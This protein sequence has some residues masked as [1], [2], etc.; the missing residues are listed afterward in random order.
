MAVAAWVA[1]ATPRLEPL[2]RPR[3]TL[4]DLARQI[5]ERSFFGPSVVLSA[6]TGALGAAV[7]FLPA[8]AASAGLGTAAAVAAVTVLA[9]ASSLVQPRVGRLR[10][11]GR[12][13]D[14]TGIS[15][16]LGAITAGVGVAAAVPLLPPGAAAACVYAAAVLI[17]VGIGVSTPL[18]FA[19][20][21]DA[22]PPERLGRTMGSAEIGREAGDAGGPLLVGAIAAASGL[23][24]GLAVLGAA[25]ALSLLAVPRRPATARP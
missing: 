23:G 18:A 21:A 25:V 5:G 7:G 2:P 12:L 19:H 20:L 3:Y 22:T 15:A 16:G 13:G 9:V 14:G 24:W 17:G 4:A 1:V 6:S 10:D 11:A 8:L